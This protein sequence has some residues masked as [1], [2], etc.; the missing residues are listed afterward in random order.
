M[1][2]SSTVPRLARRFTALLFIPLLLLAMG[3]PA[4]AEG[5]MSV[6]AKSAL[7]VCYNRDLV[8]YEQNADERAYPA[9]LTK[10][11]TALLTFE[12]IDR[13]ELSLDEMVSGSGNIWNGLSIY[14]STQNIKAGEEMCVEDLLYCMLVASANEACNVLAENISG[15]EEAF[16]ALMNQRAAELGCED[17]HF[18]NAHGLH[19]DDHY[20]TA[21]DL[22][23]ITREA[24]KYPKFLEICS[25]TDHTVPATNLSGERYFYTTNYLLSAKRIPGYTYSKAIGLKTGHTDEAGPCLIAAAKDGDTVMVSVVLDAP[26][27]TQSDGTLLR[28]SFS[29][30]KRLLE[31]GFSA[32]SERTVLKS[33]DLLGEIPVSLSREATSVVY[34]PAE[35]LT[36]FLPSDLDLATLEK[37]VV[38]DAETV[39]APVA[40]G[41]KL[42]TV[43][44]LRDG[45]PLASTDVVAVRAVSRSQLLYILARIRA[46]FSLLPVRLGLGV[47]A[48]LIVVLVVRRLLGGGGRGGRRGGRRRSAPT[49]A[50]GGYRGR[51]R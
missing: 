5:E 19:D 28:Q 45:T 30:S 48:V 17:T 8:L 9:S 49:V 26:N 32:F 47:L 21:R 22:Y 10:I 43:T 37:Q 35:D 2:R 29:E 14:G 25:A 1:A 39:E 16:V 3:L 11:M 40:E 6:N 51:K 34:Q 15:S 4:S 38:L 23:R 12:A 18:A 42:G 7:L 46:V 13:G 36:A 31:Y 41:Q 44:I 50:S 20:T 33:T 24:M 27:V